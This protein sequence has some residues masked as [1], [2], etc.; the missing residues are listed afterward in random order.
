M[1]TRGSR[2]VVNHANITEFILPGGEVAEEIDKIAKN[3]YLIAFNVEAPIRT[4]RLRGGL[5]WNKS[6][7]E[8]A[9]RTASRFYSSAGHGL[10]VNDGTSRI[11]AKGKGFMLVPNRGTFD[12]TRLAGGGRLAYE[13]W[14]AGGK[15]QFN[16]K[17]SVAGQKGQHFMEKSLRKAM[18]TFKAGG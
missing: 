18:S 1:A 17:L 16:R 14:V 15:K 3:A 13:S 9:D 2:L 7:P 12:S 11:Y 8:T 4:G 6:K 5:G 10:W